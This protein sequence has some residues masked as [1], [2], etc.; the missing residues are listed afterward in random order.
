M[1][2]KLIHSEIRTCPECATEDSVN[3]IIRHYNGFLHI[4]I[5]CLTCEYSKKVQ[6]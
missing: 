1:N 3:V 5:N 4:T 6:L 2:N